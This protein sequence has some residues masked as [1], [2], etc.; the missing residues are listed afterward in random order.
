MA[1]SPLLLRS[2][3][4]HPQKP[5]SPDV[6]QSPPLQSTYTLTSPF[7]QPPKPYAPLSPAMSQHPGPPPTE[8]TNQQRPRRTALVGETYV[9]PYDSCDETFRRPGDLRKH[10]KRHTRPYRCQ[11]CPTGFYQARD[12]KKH[13]RTHYGGPSWLCRYDGC[14][15]KFTVDD[16]LVRHIR[17]AHGV[18]VKKSSL[19]H[20]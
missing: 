4:S 11:V 10:E 19:Q 8:A 3:V 1:S 13:L 20:T 18:K 7:R 16:N 14:H 12:L 9:C 6:V 2:S 15:K 17:D 5:G